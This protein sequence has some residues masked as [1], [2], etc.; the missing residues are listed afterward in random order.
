M[1]LGFSFICA[2]DNVA[3]RCILC[4]KA[5]SNENDKKERI[6]TSE[7]STSVAFTRF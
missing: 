7:R 2:G 3:E 1:S 5:L 6:I 4:N